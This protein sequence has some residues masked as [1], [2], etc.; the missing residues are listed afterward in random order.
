MIDGFDHFEFELYLRFQ[1]QIWRN[2][3]VPSGFFVTYHIMCALL[4]FAPNFEVCS[5]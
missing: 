1:F 4:N 2:F 3:K 5:T